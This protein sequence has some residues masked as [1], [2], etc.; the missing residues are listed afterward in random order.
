MVVW[1][2]G[3]VVGHVCAVVVVTILAVKLCTRGS[4]L[5]RAGSNGMCGRGVDHVSDVGVTR[6][7]RS[8]SARSGKR[9][10][11]SLNLPDNAL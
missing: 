2:A 7:T 4:L 10:C 5:V 3:C 9:R 8:N 1:G 6:S 11:I